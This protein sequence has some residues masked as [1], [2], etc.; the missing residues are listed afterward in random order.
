MCSITNF[1][2]S[3]KK[4]NDHVIMLRVFFCKFK[5]LNDSMKNL[6]IDNFTML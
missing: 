4:I 6:E 5:N 2:Q 1:S 3:K